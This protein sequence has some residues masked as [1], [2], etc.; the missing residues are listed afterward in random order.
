MNMVKIKE[1]WQSHTQISLQETISCEEHCEPAACSCYTFGVHYSTRSFQVHDVTKPLPPMVKCAVGIRA[2]IFLPNVW[3]LSN[4]QPL[5]WCFSLARLR[6]QGCIAG[7]GL[8]NRL[9][10]HSVLPTPCSKGSP[11]CLSSVSPFSFISISLKKSLTCLI[12]SSCLLLTGSEPTEDIRI[13]EFMVPN[14]RK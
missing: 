14:C 7:R 10:F 1:V 11:G 4:R 5:L 6:Y 12:L 13:W 3:E 2:R 9:S 8:P